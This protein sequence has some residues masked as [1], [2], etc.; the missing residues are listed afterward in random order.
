M[1]RTGENSNMKSK[2]TTFDKVLPFILIVFIITSCAFVTIDANNN[3][4]HHIQHVIAQCE[5][6]MSMATDSHDSLSVSMFRPDSERS[7]TCREYLSS[8]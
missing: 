7:E 6:L 8:K 1:T 4:K 2:S 3:R 5:H